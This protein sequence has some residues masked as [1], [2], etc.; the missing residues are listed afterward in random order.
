MGQ[1][2]FWK[3]ST[4]ILLLLVLGL[5]L[6]TFFSKKSPFNNNGTIVL[7]DFKADSKDLNKYQNPTFAPDNNDYFYSKST[8]IKFDKELY[9]FDTI[10]EGTILKKEIEYT[11]IG[12]NPYFVVDVKVS[13]GCTVPHYDKAPI[14]PG[15]KGKVLVEYN[16]AGKDGFSMNKL[17]LYGNV[18]YKEIPTY[19]K[20]FVKKKK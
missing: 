6:F 11:N 8:K 16:S 9:D 1:I 12:K 17:S 13:C 15:K 3:F 2:N 18:E 20:V 19:F 14:A 7:D 4:F 10:E 5:G